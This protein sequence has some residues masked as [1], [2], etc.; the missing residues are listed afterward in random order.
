M[1]ALPCGKQLGIYRNVLHSDSIH[2]HCLEHVIVVFLVFLR[3][4][5]PRASIG[6][7]EEFHPLQ[8]LISNH[9][10][11]FPEH[12]ERLNSICVQS[13]GEHDCL[14]ASWPFRQHVFLSLFSWR[15]YSHSFAPST[16]SYIC[17][18][19]RDRRSHSHNPCTEPHRAGFELVPRLVFSP[20]GQ[21]QNRFEWKL[22]RL[23]PI[24]RTYL[25]VL[26]YRTYFHSA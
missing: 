21:Y 18:L 19:C 16:R 25:T 12:K 3:S 4:H 7:Q 11:P 23:H 8:S 20:A 1:R 17:D 22:H 13:V 24:C 9:P 14:D 2:F 26:R 10:M 15:G 5:V 6:P